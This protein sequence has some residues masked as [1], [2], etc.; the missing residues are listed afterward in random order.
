MEFLNEFMMPVVL[1][2]CLC[3]GYVIK[4]WIK[5]VDNKYIPTIVALLGIFI[6]SWINGW[7][8]TPEIVL[9]GLC[10]GL[11]STGMHQLFKQ[12]IEDKTD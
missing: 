8:I 11:G 3:V 6:A 9:V 5:D 1:G 4:K 7:Q 12:Y 2:I 10:S